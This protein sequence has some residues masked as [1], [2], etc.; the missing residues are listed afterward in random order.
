[1]VVYAAVHATV[2]TNPDF[3]ANVVV[4]VSRSCD[5]GTEPNATLGLGFGSG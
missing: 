5:N 1:M 3:L 4:V 2:D